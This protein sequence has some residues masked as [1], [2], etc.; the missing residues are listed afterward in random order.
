MKGKVLDRKEIVK[1]TKEEIEK[2]RTRSNIYNQ[3][4]NNRKNDKW[5][6]QIL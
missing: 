6:L 3:N 4:R 5:I 2:E 1:I